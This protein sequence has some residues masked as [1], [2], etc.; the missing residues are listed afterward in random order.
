MLPSL[1]TYD[2]ANIYTTVWKWIGKYFL[3]KIQT[4]A[5]F[6]RHLRS[7]KAMVYWRVRFTERPAFLFFNSKCKL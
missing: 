5:I 6:G 4:L 1:A 2:L 7:M 3:N